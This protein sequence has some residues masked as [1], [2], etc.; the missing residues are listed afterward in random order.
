[1]GQL[2]SALFFTGFTIIRF[3][4]LVHHKTN[5]YE[6]LTEVYDTGAAPNLAYYGEI[7]GTYSSF[8]MKYSSSISREWGEIHNL[9]PC[10]FPLLWYIMYKEY[11]SLVSRVPVVALV[12]TLQ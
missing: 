6:D 11:Y 4:H 5:R 10:Y 7:L 12:M 1:M 9:A 2:L 3:G 8:S